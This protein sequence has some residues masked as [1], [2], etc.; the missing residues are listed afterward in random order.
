MPDLRC[1]WPQLGGGRRP[2]PRQPLLRPVLEEVLGDG[3]GNV[4]GALDP[5]GWDCHRPL[6]R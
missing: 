6:R 3:R 5:A 1:R 2:Q 4:V